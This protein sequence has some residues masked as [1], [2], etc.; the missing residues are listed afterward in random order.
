MGIVLIDP[1]LRGFNDHH[2]SH[3]EACANYC[4]EKVGV[5]PMLCLPVDINHNVI[6]K[7]PRGPSF[8][9]PKYSSYAELSFEHYVQFLG[10]YEAALRKEMIDLEPHLDETVDLLVPNCT[11]PVLYSLLCRLKH[12]PKLN[13]IRIY[14]TQFII[15]EEPLIGCLILSAFMRRVRS[16]GHAGRLLIAMPKASHIRLRKEPYLSCFGSDVAY[17]ETNCVAVTFPP[18]SSQ[19]LALTPPVD[20]QYD[21][22]SF[23]YPSRDKLDT[24][25]LAELSRKGLSVLVLFPESAKTTPDGARAISDLSAPGVNCQIQFYGSLESHEFCKLAFRGKILYLL[26]GDNYYRQKD[27]YSGR[28]LEALSLGRPFIASTDSYFLLPFFD[29]NLD[30]VIAADPERLR[31][32]GGTAAFVNEINDKFPTALAKASSRKSFWRR[33]VTEHG[34]TDLLLAD[35]RAPADS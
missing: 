4:V 35:L 21:L 34:F 18:L 30:G 24:H 5:R 13:S 17:F 28:V 19:S 14:L 27:G 32:S 25:T 1:L 6:N 22:V 23:G 11:L 8:V 3:I 26:G 2:W 15:P 7:Y 10:W 20:Q 16:K 29:E 9:R 33:V 31:K 12:F